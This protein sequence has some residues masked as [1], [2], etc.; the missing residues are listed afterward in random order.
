MA[1]DFASPPNLGYSDHKP[2]IQTD[3]AWPRVFGEPLIVEHKVQDD[4]YYAID[5]D[6]VDYDD[7]RQPLH[8]KKYYCIIPLCKEE[9]EPYA[10]WC[11]LEQDADKKTTIKVLGPMTPE[12][13]INDIMDWIERHFE[14]LSHYWDGYQISEIMAEVAFKVDLIARKNDPVL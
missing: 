12:D 1:D 13:S 9:L 11:H 10:Y 8:S 6:N 7:D 4:P 3:D 2:D 5:Q 14:N